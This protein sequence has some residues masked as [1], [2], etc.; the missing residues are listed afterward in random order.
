VRNR[1]TK[2]KQ[3][4]NQL[5]SF[6]PLLSLGSSIIAEP[7]SGLAGLAALPFG[8]DVA[9]NAISG[10]QDSLTYQPRTEDG[11]AAM[12]SLTS[13]LAPVGEAFTGASKFLG[14]KT[15]DVT[16]SPSLAAAAY[17]VPTLALEAVGLKGA[18]SL[19]TGKALEFGGIGTQASSIGGK[20]RGIFAGV[21]AKN[22]DLKKLEAA[23]ELVKRGFDREA[24]RQKT[25]WFK[26][27]GD[28]KWEID[29]SQSSLSGRDFKS[30]I[31]NTFKITDETE[32]NAAI[33]SI[34]NDRK[35]YKEP[36]EAEVSRLENVLD[37]PELYEN[38]PNAK[39]ITYARSERLPLGN[40]L[41]NEKM[42]GIMVSPMGRDYIKSPILH[43]LQHAIQTR[44]G[45]AKGGSAQGLQKEKSYLSD[46]IKY[47][48][49]GIQRI[50]D[51]A[52]SSKAY[53]ELNLQLEK[54]LNNGDEK[55]I[56]SLIGQQFDLIESY[57]YIKEY[58]QKVRD[59]AKR[60]KEIGDPENTYRR[61][62][63]EAEA[64]NVQTRMDMSAAERAEKSPF[65]TLDIPE[66]ELIVRK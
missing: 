18:R 38:Y 59:F 12:Q 22:A 42:D 52:V 11:Q 41:Y 51:T 40:A 54:A 47:A 9:S 30:E 23:K 36:F 17:S 66:N 46:E 4:R 5:G 43:E 2:G 20:Q 33:Q 55:A 63:G 61:L 19:N 7:I 64:R 3:G 6:E 49:E 50:Q 60:R 1:P 34:A 57:P 62:A 8:A 14:D 44:E 53:Q 31:A 27:N 39:N 28:W 48:E 37:Y 65:Q 15:Y 24:I 32:R 45:F 21:R 10:V 16:G 13:A 29:D 25:G 35:N 58:K 56:D 26:E